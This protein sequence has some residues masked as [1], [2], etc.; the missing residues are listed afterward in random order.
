[1]GPVRLATFP[2]HDDVNLNG[3][4]AAR[5]PTRDGATAGFR[6][7]AAPA[8]TALRD[9]RHSRRTVP[10]AATQAPPTG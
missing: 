7:T 8:G 5:R 4:S 10:R 2:L 3:V 9:T 1:M 6:A